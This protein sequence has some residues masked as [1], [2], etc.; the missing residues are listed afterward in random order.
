MPGVTKPYMFSIASN[1]CFACI[2]TS[3]GACSSIRSIC[4][5]EGPCREEGGCHT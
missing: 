2:I 1:I 5:K 3:E 4:E